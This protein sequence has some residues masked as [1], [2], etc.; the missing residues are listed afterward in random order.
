MDRPVYSARHYKRFILN[1]LELW[2]SPYHRLVVGLLA[3]I[4][5]KKNV[6]FF[7]K[8]CVI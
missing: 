8:Q 5:T 1:S 2:S 7:Q 6:I 3:S 4:V